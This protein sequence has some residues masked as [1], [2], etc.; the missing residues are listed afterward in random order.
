MHYGEGVLAGAIANDFYRYHPYMIRALH[1][2]LQKH[3]PRYFRAH[4]QPG[5][6]TTASNASTYGTDPS[7]DD[8]VADQT[9][10]QQT[11]KI[12]TLAFYNLPLVSRV[13]ALRTDQIGKLVSISGTVTRLSLIHISEPTRPY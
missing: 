12:F 3:V 4:R 8:S 2:V 5:T 6:S 1:N 10:N 11:D 7:Q 13:R 9:P